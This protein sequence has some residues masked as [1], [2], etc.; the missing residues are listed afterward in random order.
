MWHDL[1]KEDLD[2]GT[3][4]RQQQL[5]EFLAT[6][7]IWRK[8]AD[9]ARAEYFTPDMSSVD[10]YKK[11]IE[12]YRREYWEMLGYPLTEYSPDL[13]TPEGTAE[14]VAEDTLSKIYRLQIKA[15]EG[16]TVYGILFLPLTPPPYSL[17]ISQHGGGGTPECTAGFFGSANY[18]DMTRRT[19][20]KGGIAVF[21]P[22]LIVWDKWFGPDVHPQWP[23]INVNSR[24]YLDSYLKQL[25]GSITA[26]EVFKIMRSIDYLLAN[27]PFNPDRIGMIG[28]SYGGFYTQYTTAA[29]VRI[30]SSL[31][32]CFF[33]DRF[34][35]GRPDF[36]WQNSGKKF[37]DAEVAQLICPRAQHIE[38]A[39][40]DVLF[41]PENAEQSHKQVL[42]TYT[43][44][45]IED[46]FWFNVFEGEHELCKDDAGLDFFCKML[47]E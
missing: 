2:G 43:A 21:A 38:I 4:Y 5:D 35:Y 18:N 32:S 45:G 46:K 7:E 16:H 20:R 25:G 13:P 23:E 41:D 39:T 15:M 6:L 12:T 33:N 19:L 29:D 1:Y 8:K 30:K 47:N 22:Q 31:A 28:L 24:E 10:A 27:Y 26:L 42:E 9:E 14:F 36:I 37:L 44:L 17:V 3:K 34:R 40:N 11:D